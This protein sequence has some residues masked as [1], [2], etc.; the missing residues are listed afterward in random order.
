MSAALCR[1]ALLL[2]LG[3]G[4]PPALLLA[5]GAGCAPQD[6]VVA[7][8]IGPGGGGGAGG[9]AGCAINEDCGPA[10]LCAR[11]SC[12]DPV[13]RCEARPLSCASDQAP[14][15]GCDGVSYWNDCLRRQSGVTASVPGQ[16]A[17]G[18]MACG[19]PGKI[20]C[21]LEGT[22]CAQLQFAKGPCDEGAPGTCWVLPA[23][24][25]PDPGNSAWEP[26]GPPPPR[27]CVTVCEAI[28]AGVPHRLHP[29][30]HC[31]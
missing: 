26:C 21:E 6:V 3:L 16:C 1:R 19:G 22:T 25:P 2:A 27:P 14:S 13:G 24:C 23:A 8:R 12:A 29:G 20:P 30:P 9:T 11:A 10:G 7:D 17:Q 15:C 18:A 28:Q 31:P 5:P 4:M